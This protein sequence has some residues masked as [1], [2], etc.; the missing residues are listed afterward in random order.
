L[1]DFQS[2]VGALEKCSE[3]IICFRKGDVYSDFE[4]CSSQT[5]CLVAK[6]FC[7]K[8]VESDG[9]LNGLRVKFT[10][11]K[12]AA[13]TIAQIF[14]SVQGLSDKEMPKDNELILKIPAAS[15]KC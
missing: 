12:N 1:G 15:P 3:S 13:G 2:G 14:I 8:N 11:T 10:V 9:H 6:Y 5:C 4:E 7:N